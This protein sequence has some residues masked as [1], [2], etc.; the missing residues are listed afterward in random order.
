M[1]AGPFSGTG[2][3]GGTVFGAGAGGGTFGIGTGEGIFG[4]PGGVGGGIVGGTCGNGTGSLM[5]GFRRK[6][7]RVSVTN[8]KQR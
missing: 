3:G 5:K 7:E 2:T 6:P 8:E 1:T 4:I